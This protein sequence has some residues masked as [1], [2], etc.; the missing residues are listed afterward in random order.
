MKAMAIAARVFAAVVG[1]GILALVVDGSISAT[2]GY[3]TSTARLTIGLAGGLVAGSV[4]VGVAWE[5][6]RR[7]IAWCLIVAL[8]AGEAWALLQT[9][10]R[11]IV[12]RD[13]QQAPLHAAADTRAKAAERVK[14][15]ES[16]LSAIG[17]TPRLRK[18]EAAKA[19]A[20]AAVIAKSSEKG[21]V[22]HCSKLLQAQVDAAVAEV[23]NARAEIGTKRAAAEGKLQQARADLA[24][25]PLPPSATPL[26]DRLGITGWTLDL[27]QAW[28]ASLA[29]NGLA[30]LLF[31]FAAHGWRHRAPVIDVTSTPVAEVVTPALE[32]GAA[33]AKEGAATERPARD[34]AG[35]ADLFARTTL[36]PADAGRLKLI[37]VPAAYAAW[38][39]DRGLDPLPNKEIGA[40]LSALFFS[41]GLYRQGKGTK[42]VVPGIEWR[43]QPLL[44]G[45]VVQRE[46]P[47]T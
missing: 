34:P 14:A 1:V 28:L 11:T 24:L 2:G 46:G 33:A 45:P 16:A 37:E 10:E 6:G 4:A 3:G 22:A 9:A 19:A 44:E 43:N 8:A 13:Q 42:A 27:F 40:A 23:T 41:V 38:C 7:G 5:E 31:A 15:A 47:A 30:G 18:A 25:L 35:E 32:T 29:A 36:R 17:D 39:C 21:C 26:A 12:H 20:D